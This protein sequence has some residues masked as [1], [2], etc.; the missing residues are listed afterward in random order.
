MNEQ[1]V[2]YMQSCSVCERNKVAVY[3]SYGL[4]QLLEWA[5]SLWSTIAMDFITNRPLSNGCNQLWDI[6]GSFTKIGHLVK[7]KMIGKKA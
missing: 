3:K 4:L 1:I 2:K 6:I 7:L 5:F